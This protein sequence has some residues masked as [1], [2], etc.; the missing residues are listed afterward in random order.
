MKR[1]RSNIV[2][3]CTTIIGEHEEV[4]THALV[5]YLVL[6]KLKKK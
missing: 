6:L 4:R 5:A 1:K 2:Y 3:I